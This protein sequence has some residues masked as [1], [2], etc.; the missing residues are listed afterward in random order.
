[1]EKDKIESIAFKV[2]EGEGVELNS[3][4]SLGFGGL[5]GLAVPS[6]AVIW[7][8]QNKPDYEVY[9]AICHEIAHLKVGGH[10][11]GFSIY[12]NSLVKRYDYLL[13]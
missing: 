1:M 12:F 11:L 3:V 4:K 7:I 9:K 2:A 6:F 13:K 5:R 10:G 8:N